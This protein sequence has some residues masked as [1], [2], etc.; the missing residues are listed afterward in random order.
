MDTKD[1]FRKI[2]EAWNWV[3][4][5]D[6]VL[7]WIA[8]LLLIFIFVKFIFFPSL[9]LIM[10][11]SLPLAGVESSSM[12][13]QIVD[14]GVLSLCGRYDGEKEYIDFDEYWK[15]C[16]GWYEENDINKEEFSNFPLRNGFKKGDIVIVYGRF[17]PKI[18]DVI[19]FKP[20]QESSAPRPIV[21]RIVKIGDSIETKGDHN[22]K[23]LEVN[24]NV[25]GTDET[26]IG[27]DQ[28][29]GKVVFKIPYLGWFKIWLVEFL[30]IFF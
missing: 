20:N 18:G 15:T 7:S 8:A 24:N 29:I 13:H 12:D 25:L 11:T 27:N 6:S 19:I 2:K 14:D 4:N 9:S 3:W 30:K 1:I 23:Q 17:N 10:G 21:H 16:G 5:S 28:V 26:N 22:E